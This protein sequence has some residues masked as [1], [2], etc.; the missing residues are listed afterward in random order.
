MY[1]SMH[2]AGTSGPGQKMSSEA[3]LRKVNHTQR[4]WIQD[5]ESRLSVIN[6]VERSGGGW[7]NEPS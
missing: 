4:M 3:G 6:V 5:A 1:E 7:K 2:T